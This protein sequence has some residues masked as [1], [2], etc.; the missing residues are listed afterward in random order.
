[1]WT[2]VQRN[3]G[4]A[5]VSVEDSLLLTA[6]VDAGSAK[7]R[8]ET[9]LQNRFSETSVEDLL[10]TAYV[11]VSRTKFWSETI[12]EN[13]FSEPSVDDVFRT[14]YVDVGTTKFRR[15]LPC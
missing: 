5:G 3:F 12:P 11:D 4:F 10:R 6:Y 1:M 14:T 13:R 9:S 8:S 7:F 15:K 2:L